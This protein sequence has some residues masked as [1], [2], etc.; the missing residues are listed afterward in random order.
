MA[1]SNQQRRTDN[2]QKAK[3]NEED[4]HGRRQNTPTQMQQSRAES[5]T[6]DMATGGRPAP[7]PGHPMK[8]IKRALRGPDEDRPIKP[9]SAQMWH[10][11]SKGLTVGGVQP[12]VEVRFGDGSTLR[13]HACLLERVSPYFEAALRFRRTASDSCTDA[14]TTAAPTTTVDCADGDSRMVRLLIKAVYCGA[15]SKTY[16]CTLDQ[17]IGVVRTCNMYL[18][19]VPRYIN[20]DKMARNFEI[21]S[22]KQ[23]LTATDPAAIYYGTSADDMAAAAR[24][25]N[26]VVGAPIVRS[27]SWSWC[28]YYA[29]NDEA[30]YEDLVV[31]INDLRYNTGRHYTSCPMSVPIM[32]AVQY[33]IKCYLD[34]EGGSDGDDDETASVV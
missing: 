5:N 26:A 20:I 3:E 6:I 30:D 22:Y 17:Y 18:A 32:C 7:M 16:S 28:N 34:Q 27:F 24:D 25:I 33:A 19:P 8:R 29:P 21:H 31:I 23:R 13:L 10:E 12:D 1:M 4:A 11:A 15:P 2:K 14:A 9:L